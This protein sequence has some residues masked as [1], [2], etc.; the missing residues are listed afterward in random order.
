MTMKLR[1]APKIDGE[2]HFVVFISKA[3]EGGSRKIIHRDQ[4]SEWN[5]GEKL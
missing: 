4:V 3:Q 1:H 2:D 5:E